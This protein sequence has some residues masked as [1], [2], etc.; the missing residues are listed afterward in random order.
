MAREFIP[1]MRFMEFTNAVRQNAEIIDD[2]NDVCISNS[3]LSKKIILSLKFLLN[4][5]NNFLRKVYFFYNIYLRNFKY[6]RGQSWN[7]KKS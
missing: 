4:S 2:K 7:I 3:T 1:S 5:K 6:L